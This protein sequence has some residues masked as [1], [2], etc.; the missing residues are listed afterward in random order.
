MISE[1]NSI[2]FVLVLGTVQNANQGP[3]YKTESMSK[4]QSLPIVL[5]STVAKVALAKARLALE[6][7]VFNEAKAEAELAE[8]EAKERKGIV[9]YIL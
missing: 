8:A 2:I 6:E 4:S 5:P 7:A 9:M 1:C 3:S